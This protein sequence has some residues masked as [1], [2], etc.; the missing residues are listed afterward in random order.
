MQAESG[1]EAAKG[2]PVVGGRERFGRGSVSLLS[3]QPSQREPSMLTL[4]WSRPAVADGQ[5]PCGV[6]DSSASGSIP[7]FSAL[8]RTAC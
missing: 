7:R 2:I 1:I 4:V 3:Q 8:A 5:A 6:S